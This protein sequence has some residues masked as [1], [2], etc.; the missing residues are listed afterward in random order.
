MRP[1]AG[2]FFAS[3]AFRFSL[4]IQALNYIDVL[5]VCND[6]HSTVDGFNLVFVSGY[7][8]GYVL[9]QH[10]KD[11]LIGKTDAAL[12]KTHYGFAF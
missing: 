4:E 7:F 1:R 8:R 6:F 12:L 5:V 9:Y 10:F 2:Y 3:L 11:F